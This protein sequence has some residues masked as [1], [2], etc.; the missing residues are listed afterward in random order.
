MW[1]FSL[2]NNDRGGRYPTHLETYDYC[3]TFGK[4]SLFSTT[5]SMRLKDQAVS[6]LLVRRLSLPLN[7]FSL[8]ASDSVTNGFFIFALLREYLS[9]VCLTAFTTAFERRGHR[10]VLPQL[11]HCSSALAHS[12]VPLFSPPKKGR[13]SKNVWPASC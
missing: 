3:T 1:R 7:L 13:Y 8:T 4:F 10:R 5:F 11:R 6:I 9:T 2:H 12:C